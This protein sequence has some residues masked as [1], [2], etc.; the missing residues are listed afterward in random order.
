M[1]TADMFIHRLVSPQRF[2]HH[3]LLVELHI[4]HDDLFLRLHHTF[5]WK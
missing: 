5:I 3:S 2:K 4:K 1:K